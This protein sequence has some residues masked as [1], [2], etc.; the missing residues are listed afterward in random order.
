MKRK[1]K[2][3]GVTV[4]SVLFG[5]FFLKSAA[6]GGVGFGIAVIISYFAAVVALIVAAVMLVLIYKH[7]KSSGTAA[8]KE[9][10][11]HG[12]DNDKRDNKSADDDNS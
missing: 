7:V 12:R 11:D 9:V 10:I 2:R 3:I 4:V 1:L 5:S 8:D 6:N